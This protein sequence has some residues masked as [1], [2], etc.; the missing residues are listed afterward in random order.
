MIKIFSCNGI[1]P[2][3]IELQLDSFQKYLQE[4]FE[5]IIFNS[6]L[7]DRNPEKAEEVSKVCNSR[8]IQ[9]VEVPRD[10][11][12]EM[13]RLK[14]DSNAGKL[15]DENDKIIAAYSSATA[16]YMFQWA[17]EKVISKEQG[18]ICWLHSDVFLTELIKF[19]D[20]LQE[21]PLYFNP[22]RYAFGGDEITCLG[23]DFVLADMSKLP[24]PETM[25]WFSGTIKGRPTVA[26]GFTY[27]WLQ[28]HPEV[29]WLELPIVDSNFD[30]ANVDFHPSRYQFFVLGGKR[31]LHYL[32]GAQVPCRPIKGGGH[33]D[34]S[35]AEAAEYHKKKLAWAKRVIGI[36]DDRN[37]ITVF[38]RSS[39]A[40]Y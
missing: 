40:A 9:V 38:Q 6:K 27:Y 22:R 13:L 37:R 26:G 2:Q 34:F 28:A 31:M 15:F 19:T 33:Q 4:D 5:Y 39:M 36:P 32:S 18:S 11:N 12:T 8:H 14:T 1:C 35:I 17:W 30:D 23:E 29:K 3:F 16:D 24:A 25:N 10:R 21:S 20:C 7:I